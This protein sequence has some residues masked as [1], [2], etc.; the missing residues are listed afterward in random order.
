M[1]HIIIAGLGNPGKVYEDTRHNIGFKVINAIAEYFDFPIDSNKFSSMVSSKTFA[2]HKITLVKPQTYMNLSGQAIAKIIHFYKIPSEDLIIIHDDL[3]L[4]L[5]KIKMKLAGGSGGHNGIK[6]IDQHITQN[7]YRIR[8]G[9]G[10][11]IH[12]SEV[13]SFVLSKFTNEEDKIIEAKIKA[14]VENLDYAI[15][16]NLPQFMNVMTM[17]NKEHGF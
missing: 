14:I 11:P 4:Q 7:Y 3:D 8:F 13:S 5:A 12:A 16:K 6:S 10:K 2:N 17:E 9:I 1:K 15:D